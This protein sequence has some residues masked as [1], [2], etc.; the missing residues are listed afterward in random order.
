MHTMMLV[1][2][3][4]RDFLTVSL[5][6]PNLPLKDEVYDLFDAIT[7]TF[8]FITDDG[9]QVSAGASSTGESPSG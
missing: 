9:V 4:T 1:P 5:A 3:T 6:S 8:R 7:S 2:G